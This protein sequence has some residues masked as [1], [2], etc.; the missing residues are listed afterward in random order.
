MDLISA[1]IDMSAKTQ[2]NVE[3][4]TTEKDKNLELEVKELEKKIQELAS[5]IDDV[6]DEKQEITNQLKRVLADYQNLEKSIQKR[7]N[8]MYMQSRKSLA[9]KLIPLVDD[10]TMA[11]LAKDEIDF[12]EKGSSWANGVL[13]IFNNLEKSLEEIGVKKYV[14]EK[15]ERFDPQLHEALTVIEGEKEGLIFDVIQPGY[16]LDDTVVRPARVVVTKSKS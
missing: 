8:L 12:G 13:G 16:V 3:V 4:K 9:E 7:L 11:I 15:D 1:F 5:I 10:I 2:K 14:P 6:E